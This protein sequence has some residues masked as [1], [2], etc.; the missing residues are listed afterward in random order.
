MEL[1]AEPGSDNCVRGEHRLRQH[2]S[3]TGPRGSIWGTG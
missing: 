2:A 1:D 3:M